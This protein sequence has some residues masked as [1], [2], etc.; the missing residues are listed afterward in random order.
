[1]R[2]TK[3]PDN[4]EFAELY[5]AILADY[6]AIYP[7][8]QL[9]VTRDSK[10]VALEL[11]SRGLA[12]L[13]LDL[14][15]MGK[16]LDR[17]L[18]EGRLVDHS[19][20]CFGA[21]W[22][23]SPIPRLFSG[24][25][26]RLFER[27]GQ[28]REDID[29]DVVF[30]L[31]TL[32]YACKKLNL[33]CKPKRVYDAVKEYFDVD[34]SLPSDY[35]DRW[36]HSSSSESP[37]RS[38]GLRS[39]LE[40][41]PS[42]S[43][44]PV[45]SRTPNDLFGPS[46]GGVDLR[47][48]I[49]RRNA[50][51]AHVVRR[52]RRLISDLGFFDPEDIEGR[53]GPGAVSEELQ[54]G[55]KYMFPTWS[56]RLAEFF[57]WDVYGVTT[58]DNFLANSLPIQEL[59]PREEESASKLIAVPKTQKS[60]RLIAS[61]PVCNQWIQQGIAS[62]LRQRVASSTLGLSI[63]FFD[64][65]PSRRDALD[66]SRH[67]RRSTID[68]SSA[69][70]RLSCKLVESI[71]EGNHSL[72]DLLAVS[73]TRYLVNPIDKKQPKL[74]KLRKFASMGSALT[75][76]VQSIVFATMAIGVGSYLHPKASL[77]SLAQR[78][79]VFGDD[80]ILPNKWVETFVEL[81][82]H[83]GL[84]VNLSKTFTKGNFRESCGMDAWM[85]YDVTPPYVRWPSAELNSRSAVGYVAVTNNFFLKGLWRTAAFLETAA[86]WV[87]KLP[88]INVR[89]AALGRATFCS[90]VDPVI[91]ITWDPHTQQSG[92][93]VLR[94]TNPKPRSYQVDNPNGMM[95]YTT[96][97]KAH[98]YSWQSLLFP[99][100]VYFPLSTLHELPPDGSRSVI[101]RGWTPLAALSAA[102]DGRP[103]PHLV[104]DVG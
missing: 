60:P 33:D 85:G 23:T 76:P 71:F 66:A 10:R 17:S 47:L 20:P 30:Y 7:A 61:E 99:K 98:S 72:L 41:G 63:D 59:V 19:V 70:D 18:S 87:R 52:A 13:T 4:I 103:I 31:R 95:E 36:N 65:E 94:V 73:R 43:S 83:V 88:A 51:Y 26:I 27:S 92:V 5:K 69:S 79:R 2:E 84:K 101:R 28:L 77:R 3:R 22:N 9:E 35:H 62:L 21:R 89:A 96:C 38:V 55:T 67:G 42:G 68:L 29:P 45:H 53:H 50:V 81:L 37:W 91:P 100:E 104:R 40:G 90:G 54:S 32:L 75:F 48:A 8:D 39:A 74:L 46:G 78:V 102:W 80:I 93:R 25:W 49:D 58:V 56:P 97:R 11:R 14:P 82:T 64:Q 12:F 34:S 57:P 24:F 16:V 86:A 44:Y 1:M 15:E 6:L